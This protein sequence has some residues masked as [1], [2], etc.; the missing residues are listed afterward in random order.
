MLLIE[1]LI[2]LRITVKQVTQ[3]SDRFSNFSYI[4][5]FKDKKFNILKCAL[6]C[7]FSFNIKILLVFLDKTISSIL[8]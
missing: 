2:K 7:F 6:F 8:T 1:H 4:F 5:I 3:T